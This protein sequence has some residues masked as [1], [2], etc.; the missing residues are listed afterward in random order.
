MIMF[1]RFEVI[2]ALKC[3]ASQP[4]VQPRCF[5]K[6]FRIKRIAG[7]ILQVL[8]SRK[9]G[10]VRFPCKVH[11]L[12]SREAF[13]QDVTY[14]GTCKSDARSSCLD[15]AESFHSGHMGLHSSR[16]LS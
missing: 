10:L 15:E 3:G 9:K 6:H 12:S 16:T 5:V 14:Q 2:L 13:V 4:L 11:F 8:V 7:E 1:D